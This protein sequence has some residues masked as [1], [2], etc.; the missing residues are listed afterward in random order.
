M[1]INPRV[2]KI[3]TRVRSGKLNFFFFKKAEYKPH[4]I[5]P[6]IIIK[7]PLLK[8][9]ERIISKLSLVI[10][11]KIPKTEIIR[12]IIWYLFVCSILNK[13]HN[14]IMIAGMAVLKR[15]AFITWVWTNDKY[16]KELNK[17]TLVKAKNNKSGK[18]SRIIFLCLI[19][20]L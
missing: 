14:R 5:T 11:D 13:K 19:I 9:N 4:E 15:E 2:H 10:I 1:K 6:P 17:P 7:S 20:S 18:F 16:V 12:P 3:W 8:F